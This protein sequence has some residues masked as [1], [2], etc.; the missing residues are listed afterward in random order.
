[1]R[2]RPCANNGEWAVVYRY[3]YTAAVNTLPSM[4]RQTRATLSRANVLKIAVWQLRRFG[5]VCIQAASPSCTSGT[6]LVLASSPEE[7]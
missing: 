5:R 2:Q 1:M 7:S 4:G 6:L 3:V